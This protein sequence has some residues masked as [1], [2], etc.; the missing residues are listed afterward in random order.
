MSGKTVAVIGAGALGL[1]ATKTFA[2]DGFDVTAYESRDYIGGLWKDSDDSTISVHSTTIFNS[3]KFR[4]AYSD[5]PFADSDD[6]YPTAAQLH[7]YLNRYSECFDLVSKINLGTKVLSINRSADK[8]TLE[9]QS[10]STGKTTTKAFDRVCIATGSF[11]TPRWPKLDG[12]EKFEGKVIHSIDYH[13][14]EDFKDQ[15]VLA[16]GMHATAQDVTNSL[17]ESAKKVYLSH[18]GGL[19]LVPRY[20]E[21]GSTFDSS[22]TLLV[23]FVMGWMSSHFPR[24]LNWMLDRALGKIS[25]KAFPAVKKEWGLTPAPSLAV[26]TPLMAD[27]LWPHLQS[28]FAE[29]VPEIRR[30][31]GPRTVEL[32]SGRILQDIDSIIYCTGYQFNIP[33]GLIPKTSQN[34]DDLHPYPNN[35][36][37]QPPRLYRN[38]F[39]LHRDPS[40]CSSLAF[41]GQGA[42]VFPG[43]VQFEISSM[44]I[45][46]IWQGK[47][48]LPSYDGM[49]EWRA[50]N[51][52][53]RKAT[54][55]Y[56]KPREGSTFY[57]AFVN[58]GNQLPWV[59]A[60]AGTG[61]YKNLGAAW[62]NWRAWKLW[63]Q[64]KELYYLC[65]KGLFTPAIWRLFET[66]KRK[67][68]SREECRALIVRQNEMAEESRKRKLESKKKD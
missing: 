22:G 52:A 32:S 56:Y 8:W 1:V 62:F 17:S 4:A 53:E 37:G 45:S 24:L 57:P 47:S 54:M 34:T 14:S 18:R 66:G 55:D 65:M 67:A 38:I 30:I 21:S 9:V 7:A 64:D 33:E 68:M 35:T 23:T 11:Y 2:E 31:T 63:W 59:D 12:L 19:L 29:P 5:F 41:L 27:T 3:S 43:F 51:L 61:L 49:L 25:Q 15:T 39:P 10:K 58:M 13:R 60:T 48:S 16:V 40:I 20:T 28:G 6:D 50:R 36:V 26:S 42:F 44:A 46:Q